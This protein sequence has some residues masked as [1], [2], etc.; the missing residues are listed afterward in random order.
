MEPLDIRIH[1]S[2][3]C[4]VRDIHDLRQME[5]DSATLPVWGARRSARRTFNTVAAHLLADFG[6]VFV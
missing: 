4:T 1:G 6:H 3:V 2:T 5:F